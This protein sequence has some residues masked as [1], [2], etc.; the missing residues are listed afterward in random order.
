MDD[1]ADLFT[2]CSKDPNII[3]NMALNSINMG[4]YEEAGYL[5]DYA[6]Y[7][8]DRHSVNETRKINDYKQS[9]ELLR[10]I[11]KNNPDE[12]RELIMQEN[13]ADL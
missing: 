10:Y 5:L 1:K 11:L 7:F 9:I 13:N 8:L 3:I 6:G 4:D 2:V 12:F